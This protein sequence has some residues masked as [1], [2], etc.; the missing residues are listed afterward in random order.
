MN[1]CIL[2]KKIFYILTFLKKYIQL[3][4]KNLVT[5]QPGHS[6]ALKIEKKFEFFFCS[7][8]I[9]KKKNFVTFIVFET[10]SYLHFLFLDFEALRTYTFFYQIYLDEKGETICEMQQE[11]VSFAATH[12]HFMQNM[13]RIVL[14]HSQGQGKFFLLYIMY[15]WLGKNLLI[16]TDQNF[17]LLDWPILLKKRLDSIQGSPCVL[18]LYATMALKLQLL[19]N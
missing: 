17:D 1:I 10:N 18:L 7:I 15:V 14:L 19:G 6:N 3:I 9:E 5:I 2:I 16:Y 4:H 8:K 13:R 11:N 12:S